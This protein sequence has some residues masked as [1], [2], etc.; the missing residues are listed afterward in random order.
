M[1]AYYV[2]TQTQYTPCPTKSLFSSIRQISEN[3]LWRI[4]EGKPVVYRATEYIL[5]QSIF[6]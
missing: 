2:Q 6:G 4:N 1:S 3:E 5:A